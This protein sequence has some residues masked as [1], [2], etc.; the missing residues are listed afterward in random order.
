MRAGG[1]GQRAPTVLGPTGRTELP[2]PSPRTGLQG[3]SCRVR[4]SIITQLCYRL[5]WSGF[6]GRASLVGRN[7]LENPVSTCVQYVSCYQL[8]ESP[9]SEGR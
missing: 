4:L 6:V 1:H 7:H 8:I 9:S 5:R 3:Q 2:I